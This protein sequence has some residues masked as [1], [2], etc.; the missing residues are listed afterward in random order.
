LPAPGDIGVSIVTQPPSRDRTL[1]MIASAA[2]RRAS[3]STSATCRCRPMSRS[4]WLAQAGP[5]PYL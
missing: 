5:A 3:S 4:R 1:P 2:H